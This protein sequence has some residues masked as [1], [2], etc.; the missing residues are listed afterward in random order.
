M[1]HLFFGLLDVNLLKSFSALL[2]HNHAVMHVLQPS[3]FPSSF[4]QTVAAAS[5]PL[6]VSNHIKE[7]Q[8]ASSGDFA[9]ECLYVI[10]ERGE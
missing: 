5:S 9:P 7:R 2:P 6:A 4:C 8:R 3:P 10:E 1:L